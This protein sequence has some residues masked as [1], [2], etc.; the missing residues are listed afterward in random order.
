MIRS[1]C[2]NLVNSRR[3]GRTIR[4]R[5]SYEY[6]RLCYHIINQESRPLNRVKKVKTVKTKYEPTPTPTTKRKK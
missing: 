6:C 1:H 4:A 3:C 5:R 2:T